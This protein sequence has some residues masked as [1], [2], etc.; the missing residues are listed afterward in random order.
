MSS[1]SLHVRGSQGS[2]QA[3]L[4]VREE[5][6]EGQEGLGGEPGTGRR[7]FPGRSVV[8]NPP[9]NAGHVDSAPGW[10]RSLQE[11]M[12]TH[13]GILAWEIRWTEEFGGL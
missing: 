8:K 11:E 12:T 4:K 9:C 2:K 10:R 5:R 3:R 1:I 6:Q 7:D 13:S